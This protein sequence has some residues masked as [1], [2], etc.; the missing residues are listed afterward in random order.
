ML[1]P[2]LVKQASK[3]SIRHREQIEASE[4]VGCYSC[5]RIYHKSEIEEWTDYESTALCNYCAVDSIL[6][7]A[8]PYPITIETLQQLKKYWFS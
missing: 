2:T 7:D 5:L 4:M 6:G 1:T 3:F 8:S